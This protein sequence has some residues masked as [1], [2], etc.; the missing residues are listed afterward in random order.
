MPT[1]FDVRALASTVRIELDDSLSTAEQ[2]WL[3]T[4]WVDLAHDAGGEPDQVI[5]AGLQ[6]QSDAS[7]DGRVIRANTP[8]ALAQRVTSEVTTGAIGGL[9]GEAL[10]LHASA[11]TLDDGRVIGFVGPSGRGKTTA[12]QALGR[13]YGYVTD[14]T[15]AVRVD[16]S[17]VAYP[18]PLSIGSR[19]GAKSTESASM[20]GL[21]RAPLDGLRLAA[22]VLLDRLPDVD[23]PFVESVPV[24]EAMAALAPQT[25]QLAALQHPL[26]T[27]FQTIRS[28][29]GVRR[30]V[31]AEASTLPPLID[32]VLREID[33]DAPIIKDVAKLSEHAYVY[34][35]DPL[36]PQPDPSATE[37]PGAFWRAAYIDALIVDDALL[38]LVFGSVVVLT[39]V[40]PILWLAA[41]G[42]TEEELREIALRRLPEPSQ[43]VDV[44]AV[45]SDALKGL[46]AA[47]ILVRA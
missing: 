46:V 21:R 15:L 5:R 3:K 27:L 24:I 12:A 34:S 47:S 16:G 37:R 10:I 4:H 9:R 26:R 45:I 43:G 42:L 14:E 18:K 30:V 17:V 41:D 33:H 23:R 29:G 40:G 22:L 19:P 32:D 20:L 1:A 6:T 13:A 28:T 35:S 39:G 25:S 38:V 36:E 11:V 7:E 2:E 44:D 31:Y 8:E